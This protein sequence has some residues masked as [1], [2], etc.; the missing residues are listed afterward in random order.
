MLF[1]GY[2]QG[3]GSYF[4]K[5]KLKGE[6]FLKE[7]NISSLVSIVKAMFSIL[8][9]D[10]R[11]KLNGVS[12]LFCHYPNLMSFRYIRKTIFGWANRDEEVAEIELSNSIILKD[13]VSPREKGIILISFERELGKLCNKRVLEEIEDRYHVI[14]LPSWTGLFSPEIL[15][16]ASMAKQTWFV[17]PVHKKEHKYCQYLGGFCVPLEYNAASWVNDELFSPTDVERDIDCLIVANFA[18]FKRHWI[19]FDAI[20]NI[21]ENLTVYCVGVSWGG[22]T[23]T[24][25]EAEAELFGVLDRVEVVESP[26]QEI[27]R[28]YYRRAKIFCALSYREGSFIAVAEALISGTPV[29][30]FENSHIGTRSL[31]NPDNSFIVRSVTELSEAIKRRGQFDNHAIRQAAVQENSAKVNSKRLNKDLRKHILAKESQEWTRDI[32]SFY[33]VRL[34]FMYA[35]VSKCYDSSSRYLEFDNFLLKI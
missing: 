2:K 11:K 3:V 6:N 18:S 30:M 10:P 16:F 19:L 5:T 7:K 29:V 1:R 27:L 13:Y 24:E 21:Q 35:D 28:E 33:S 32:S 25:I 14:F 4:L 12:N 17:M 22:R 26:T 31:L 8:A 34:S 15:C 23:K 20:S 9:K